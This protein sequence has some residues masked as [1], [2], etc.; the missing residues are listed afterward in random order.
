VVGCVC[1]GGGGGRGTPPPPLHAPH[2]ATPLPACLHASPCQPERC[3]GADLLPR[4]C[5]SCCTHH[6][7]PVFCLPPPPNLQGKI[8]TQSRLEGDASRVVS[9]ED[10][11]CETTE[12]APCPLPAE[13]VSCWTGGV[14]MGADLLMWRLFLP[15]GHRHHSSLQPTV[16]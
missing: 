14:L 3:A 10:S 11:P 9:S 7:S 12:T 13:T 8:E 1:V 5:D 16:G 4:C 15:A 2:A 6:S